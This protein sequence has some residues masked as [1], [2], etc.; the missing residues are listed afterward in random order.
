MELWWGYTDVL[1][2]FFIAAIRRK[3]A[4]ANYL[5][6]FSLR[7]S[8]PFPFLSSFFRVHPTILNPAKIFNSSVTLIE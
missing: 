4:I 7:V 8:F 6:Q 1:L 3:P 5:E 2:I